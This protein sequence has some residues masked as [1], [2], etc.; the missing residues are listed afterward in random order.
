MAM[1][2][3]HSL[4]IEPRGLL[5]SEAELWALVAALSR[6]WLPGRT[7]EPTLQRWSR[8]VM[9]IKLL[10]STIFETHKEDKQG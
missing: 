9:S 4:L 3:E 10:A 6:R 7:M 8:W 1:I 5:E 2:E